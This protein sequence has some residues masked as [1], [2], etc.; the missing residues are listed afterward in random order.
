M[1]ILKS[2]DQLFK[3]LADALPLWITP[4][5][6]AVFRL[7]M[8]VPIGYFALAGQAVPTA[9]LL[10]A[11]YFTDVLDGVLARSRNQ[12][13]KA[14]AVLDPIADKVI[15]LVLF[16][17]LG[18]QVLDL[19]IFTLLALI[20]LVFLLTGLIFSL[21]PSKNLPDRKF[22]ANI[23]GKLK[24]VFEVVGL[25]LLIVYLMNWP[26]VLGVAEITF[27]LAIAFALASMVRH[28]IS[29]NNID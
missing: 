29:P 22:G 17:I 9:F 13:T 19:R 4:N 16:W 12:V 10:V 1:D 7:I 15:F 2:K 20:E 27:G 23:Y 3:P 18:W 28:I 11:A 6:L 14:G 8:V 21:V 24:T 26:W 25:L 5:G